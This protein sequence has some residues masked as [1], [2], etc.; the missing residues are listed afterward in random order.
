[1]TA[2]DR[3]QV[4]VLGLGAMGHALAAALVAAGHTTTVWNRSPGRADGLV[5]QG[6]AVAA[7]A[8]AAV[9]AGEL[10]VVCL[11]DHASVHEVLDPRRRPTSPAARSST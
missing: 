9:R 3:V 11:L 2:N 8:G 5:E 6:A 1:M 7:T 10:V 4:S